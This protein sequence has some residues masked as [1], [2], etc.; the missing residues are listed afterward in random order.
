MIP[1]DV[2]ANKIN[3]TPIETCNFLRFCGILNDDGKPTEFAIKCNIEIDVPNDM[4]KFLNPQY[5]YDV[6]PEKV[7]FED[8][9]K[10][11]FQGIFNYIDTV[12]VK[13][14]KTEKTYVSL[15]SFAQSIGFKNKT[16]MMLNDNMLDL[17]NE[18]KKEFNNK[19]D[20]RK[21]PNPLKK[22]DNEK[23]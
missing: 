6:T 16:E 5:D 14:K 3:K 17:W 9:E 2:L 10:I 23:D 22:Q 1:L 15:D 21:F 12:I 8:D 20:I 11:F 18:T 13:N 7:L 19:L 4:I